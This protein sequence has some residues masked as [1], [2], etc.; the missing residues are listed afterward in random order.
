MHEQALTLVQAL[1]F[2]KK[3]PAPQMARV[4]HRNGFLPTPRMN[5]VLPTYARHYPRLCRSTSEQSLAERP[6]LSIA[7]RL[8]NQAH[9]E[10]C[11]PLA[12]PS[13]LRALLG[14]GNVIVN[15]ERGMVRKPRLTIHLPGTSPCG[16]LRM[17]ELVVQAPTHIIGKGCTAMTPPGVHHLLGR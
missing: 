1:A 16:H 5:R 10:D 3:C 14:Q 8:L 6:R 9:S 13:A 2:G 12:Q 15:R 7:S 11:F 17:S 4:R